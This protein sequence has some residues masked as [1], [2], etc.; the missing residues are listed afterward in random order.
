MFRPQPFFGNIPCPVGADSGKCGLV[1]CLFSHNAPPATTSAPAEPAPVQQQQKHHYQQVSS[2]QEALKPDGALYNGGSTPGGDSVSSGSMGGVALDMGEIELS[3]TSDEEMNREDTGSRV[4]RRKVDESRSG[5]GSV[6]FKTEAAGPGP[7]DAVGGMGKRV[8]NS[9]EVCEEMEG[10]IKAGEGKG[11]EKEVQARSGTGG[12]GGMAGAGRV[13]TAPLALQKQQQQLREQQKRMASVPGV[14]SVKPKATGQQQQ[15]QAQDKAATSLITRTMTSTAVATKPPS[16]TS[17]STTSSSKTI[18]PLSPTLTYA[19]APGTK[20]TPTPAKPLLL[21]PASVARCSAKWGTRTQLLTLLHGEYVRLYQTTQQDPMVV[22]I[23]VEEEAEVARSKGAVYPNVM[24]NRITALKKA[25][26]KSVEWAGKR[27]DIERKRK[28]ELRKGLEEL[29]GNGIMQV[30]REVASAG[31]KGLTMSQGES[32]AG[33]CAAVAS[34][35]APPSTA[36]TPRPPPPPSDLINDPSLYK[37]L[38]TGLTPQEE[39]SS[40]ASLVHPPLILT[41]YGHILTPPS[42]TDIAAAQSGVST[43]QGWEICERCDSRFQTF[44]GRRESDGALASGGKC[45]YHWGRAVLPPKSLTMGLGAP[46]KSYTCCKQAVGTSAGCVMGESH[47]FKVGDVKRLAG[48]WQWVDTYPSNLVTVDEGHGNSGV[49]K[50]ARAFALDC[51][52]CYTTLGMEMVRLTV[53]DFPGGEVVVDALVR[54]KGEILDLNSRFSGVSAKDYVSAK[55]YSP[56]NSKSGLGIFPS[57]EAAREEVLRLLRFGVD[58]VGMKMEEEIDIQ[59][60][61]VAV[62]IGHALENDLNVLRLCHPYIVDTCILFPHTRGFPVRNKLAWVAEKFLKWRIQSQDVVMVAGEGGEEAKGVVKGHDSA[63]DAR[64]AGELVRWKI[65][66]SV[67]QNDGSG[68]AALGK[69]AG[70]GKGRNLGGMGR[71]AEGR[72]LRFDGVAAYVARGREASEGT[73]NAEGGKNKEGGKRKRGVFRESDG[74]DGDAGVEGESTSIGSALQT[75]ATFGMSKGPSAAAGEAK[76]NRRRSLGTGIG[77]EFGGF[78][79]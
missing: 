47:V 54:P 40:L 1:H 55:P 53:V 66:E 79:L 32:S 52:M 26:A 60:D 4:K 24:K 10:V 59:E 8:V 78:G 33:G 13:N 63:V 73:V 76:D 36:S 6:S 27:K 19:K 39:V 69:V 9:V 64:C 18:T 37:P 22:T 43:S 48:Q 50:V 49:V 15:S 25:D 21:V 34:A 65:K 12:A 72:G 75:T 51:E 35:S 16:I 5:S 20:P 29:A 74:E 46:E 30:K 57:P 42:S 68:G 61:G 31:G 45:T 38:T 17:S 71:L 77:G 2:I 11:E 56:G 44:P 41:K 70:V 23:A 28:G 7:E 62:L 67:K 58:S 3:S 14:Q